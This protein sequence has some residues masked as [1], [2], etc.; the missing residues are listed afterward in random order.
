MGVSKL[1]RLMGLVIVATMLLTT[2]SHAQEKIRYGYLP[3]PTVPLFAAEAH[4]L[5]KKYGLDVELVKFTSGPTEFQALQSQ[6][7]DLAQGA[8]AAFYMASSRKLKAQ[9]VYSFGDYGSLEGV[10]LRPGL[11]LSSYAEL[12]GKKVSAPSGSIQSLAHVYAMRQAGLKEGS[13]ELVSLAPPQAVAALANGDVDAAWFYEPFFSMAQKSGGSVLLNSA[14]LGVRDIFG[15]AANA[16]WLSKDSNSK[17]LSRLFLAFNEGWEMYRRDP[18]KTLAAI[19]EYTGVDQKL[20]L[21]II[22][23]VKWYSLQDQSAAKSEASLSD[24]KNSNAGLGK[25][26]NWIET[27]ALA[28]GLMEKKGNPTTFLNDAAASREAE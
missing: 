16:E 15:V 28:A 20:A 8:L 17:A 14:K 10:V 22:D 7:I 11:K 19:K 5:F 18:K 24:P 23:G 2:A 21:Q 6:S 13:V 12:S 9:W 27:N 1:I 3:V 25:T 4:G 26:L